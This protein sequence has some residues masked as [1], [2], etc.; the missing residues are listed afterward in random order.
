[1]V[2]IALSWSL[3]YL[4]HSTILSL[5]ALAIAAR[6]RRPERRATVLRAGLFGA[7]ATATLASALP[8]A[9]VAAVWQPPT[10]RALPSEASAS[11]SA[12]IGIEGAVGATALPADRGRRVDHVTASL[13]LIAA[14]SMVGAAA[15]LVRRRRWI[16][17][18]EREPVT[19]ERGRADLVEFV[20]RADV[21][22]TRSATLDGPVA[23]SSRE[24]C[25]PTGAWDALS[26]TERR[27][28]LAHEAAHFVRRDPALLLAG[29]L[30]E[31]LAFFQPLHRLVRARAQVAA[32]LAADAWAVTRTD[33][34]LGYA[35]ALHGFAERL[36]APRRVPAFVA[37][38]VASRPPLAE[39]VA[40][41]L[42]GSGETPGR[43]ERWGTGAAIGALLITLA[44][45][46]PRIDAGEQESGATKPYGRF[47]QPGAMA[48]DE[49]VVA[50]DGESRA[51]AYDDAGATLLG[52][53]DITD[54]SGRAA[55]QEALV[56]ASGPPKITSASARYGGIELSEK[57]L[58]IRAEE[59]T[60]FRDVQWVME[61]CGASILGL[62]NL[63]FE[64]PGGG[65]KYT[66]ALPGDTLDEVADD[67]RRLFDIRIDAE[68]T[69]YLL[70]ESAYA[71]FFPVEIEEGAE[72]ESPAVDP[73]PLETTDRDALVQDLAARLARAPG[74][75][76][77]IDPRKGTTYAEVLTLLDDVLGAGATDIVFKGTFER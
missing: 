23:L 75:R 13:A 45:A 11:S 9:D 26:R 39:R 30:V 51:T 15:V 55:L 40:L 2:D 10:E 76:V 20:G 16:A 66:Y 53:F 19:D 31:R 36:H 1:M 38:A 3:T 70:T 14:L 54:H 27:A 60:P 62:W 69:R 47:A 43:R 64:L 58:R 37:G 56:K 7:V 59:D 4:V 41:A 6:L 71:A 44:C 25:V 67:R 29:H 35:R 21:R 42:D 28:L 32:E 5:L 49:L 8:A 77:A 12:R 72:P 65:G 17:S 68:P 73:D 24:V 61:R 63:Q 22:L 18:L 52:T 50:I 74:S 33:D 48:G 57:V 34:A 46:G